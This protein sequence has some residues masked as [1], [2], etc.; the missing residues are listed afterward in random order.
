MTINFELARQMG[1][2]HLRLAPE[3]LSTALDVDAYRSICITA[4]ETI[5][6]TIAGQHLLWMLV[7][8]LARQFAVVHEVLIAVPDVPSTKNAFFSGDFCTRDLPDSLIKTIR[9]IGGASIDDGLDGAVA[10]NRITSNSKVA[11]EII[12]GSAPPACAAMHRLYCYG[13]GWS[14][15]VGVNDLSPKTN[16]RSE[17]AF[18][19]YFAAC[20]AAG[21]AHKYLR[22]I[23]KE[24]YFL[25]HV[26][27]DLWTLT[28][29]AT[30]DDLPRAPEIPTKLPH[31]Y[32][33]GAGAVGQGLAA[34]VCAS[35]LPIS[36]VTVVDH[37]KV[38]EEGTNLNRCVLS[39]FSDRGKYKCKITEDALKSCGISAN[40][41]NTKWEGFVLNAGQIKQPPE[42]ASL[43]REYK[44]S[45]ALS[46]VDI[47]EAR[48]A[49]QKSWPKY[50]LGG[51]TNSFCIEINEYDMSS[52]L[53][54]LMCSNPLEKKMT[55]EEAART[56]SNLPSDEQHKI[57]ADLNLDR[58]GMLSYHAK[59][60][61]GSSSE[62]DL[63]KFADSRT[64]PLPS[65]G[66]VS[67]GTGIILASHY[68]RLSITGK[69]IMDQGVG[70][71]VRFS[72]LNPR[73]FGFSKHSRNPTCD[74]NDQGHRSYS[75]LWGQSQNA[76]K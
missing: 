38:D 55:I 2:R 70:N 56:F 29:S 10:A 8:L 1:D 14:A 4:D 65:V 7:N 40:S 69:S 13:D 3:I 43:E 72:F 34:T 49:L 64:G 57:A 5:A 46:C 63:L 35:R 37:D 58:S 26:F 15:F 54:C 51:S 74:C 53:Q 44:F 61:C 12:V 39:N 47:N 75:R 6:S 67:V 19:P 33:V 59:P 30:W 60:V 20:I 25:D 9:Q 52:E 42:I 11:L 68:V 62:A 31:F 21:E 50:L 16:P 23:I 17:L 32:L 45:L 41:C 66:F 28:T 27:I 71:S 36:H 22:G 18:G 76:L 73:K 48:H 24:K